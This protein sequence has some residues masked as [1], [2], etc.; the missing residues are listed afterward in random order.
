MKPVS[1]CL[2]ALFCCL[3]L[4]QPL[5]A[6]SGGA[7]DSAATPAGESSKDNRPGRPDGD[8]SK[9]PAQL[10]EDADTYA[11]KKFAD[12]KKRNMPFDKQLE[13]KIK[14]EQRD[15]AA[16]H[17]KVL[18]ARKLPD[19]D[20]YYLGLLYNLARDF[21]NALETMRRY[22]KANPEA[23]GEPAQ[24]ARAIIIIQAA[25]KGLLPEAEARLEEYARGEPQVAEDRLSLENWVTVGYFNQQNYQ[26][27]LPHA[28]ELWTAAREA[29]K[30]K[31]SFARDATLNEAAVTLS[32]ID[33]GAPANRARPALGKS[34]QAGAAT[35]AANRR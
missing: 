12:F 7:K 15:L 25:K 35:A 11:R 5:R 21:D 32:E 9:S 28:K 4:F 13:E 22:L 17:A 1:L 14:Q 10:F 30:Q 24:N 2:I 31:S 33:S 16:Q 23:A 18:A 29:A 26:R 19:N 8:E 6:Q 27:A 20:R 3:I 34:L